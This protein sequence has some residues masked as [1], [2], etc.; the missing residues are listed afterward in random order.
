MVVFFYKGGQL[1]AM[2]RKNWE[3]T[4]FLEMDCSWLCCIIEK[5]NGNIIASLPQCCIDFLIVAQLKDN[6]KRM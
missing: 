3:F 1:G 4:A 5:R 2:C 6:F